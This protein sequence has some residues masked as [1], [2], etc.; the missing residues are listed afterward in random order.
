MVDT[1][2][3]Y[4]MAGLLPDERAQVHSR[5]LAEHVC[6]AMA[7]AGGWLDFARFMELLLY[8]PGLGYYAAGS[9]KFGAA[10]D[11]IT[12]PEMTPIFARTLANPVGGILRE[13]G[14][15]EK[16]TILELGAGSGKL[17]RDLLLALETPPQHYLILEVSPD[18]RQRQQQTL[19][20]LPEDLRRRVQWRDCWPD[21]V[22]GVILANEVLDALPFHRLRHTGGQW[23]QGGVSQGMQGWQWDYRPLENISLTDGLPDMKDFPD[24]YETE[25]CPLAEGWMAT[26]AASLTMGCAILIDYG[27][28]SREYYHPQRSNGTLMCHY[29]HHAHGDVFLYPGLQDITAH[30]DFTR[31]AR[32]ARHHGLKVK[33]WQ[34]QAR[35]LIDEG[36][37][38]QLEIS[39]SVENP[40]YTALS[41]VQTL[42]SPAEMGELFKVLVLGTGDNNGQAELELGC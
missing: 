27:F 32:V 23:F 25:V 28:P 17:A 14:E 41:A 39:R 4:E 8:A 19:A 2:L 40:D 36:I 24:P 5:Q 11:F 42:L 38:Q 26:L 10:G 16:T 15:G 29:R 18:L 31:L 35:W 12:A 34:N 20:A 30:V 37:I 13:L 9:I 6:E 7:N 22:R 1:G 21:D 33:S 3:W